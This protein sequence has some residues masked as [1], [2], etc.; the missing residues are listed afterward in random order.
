MRPAC[1][2]SVI[3]LTLSCHCVHMLRFWPPLPQSLSEC[4]DSNYT[5]SADYTSEG[6]IGTVHFVDQ[7]NVHLHFTRL[8]CERLTIAACSVFPEAS[9]GKFSVFCIGSLF[10]LVHSPENYNELY[11]PSSGGRGRRPQ[12]QSQAQREGL[13]SD[14]IQVQRPGEPVG[15]TRTRRRR[16]NVLGGASQSGITCWKEGGAGTTQQY[17]GVDEVK[18]AAASSRRERPECLGSAVQCYLESERRGLDAVSGSSQTTEH[19]FLCQR[20]KK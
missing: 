6:F 9:L 12:P 17:L 10:F 7:K 11:I 20:K 19:R 15:A 13:R 8:L 4:E 1:C 2:S 14:Q 3:E 5:E 16:A 18:I